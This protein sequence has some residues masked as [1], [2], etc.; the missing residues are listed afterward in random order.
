[1]KDSTLLA[2]PAF[3]IAGAISACAVYVIWGR[4]RHPVYSDPYDLE[5]QPYYSAV[6]DLIVRPE[7][8][9]NDSNNSG[10]ST[11]AYV[12][13]VQM[14][15]KVKR[16]PNCLTAFELD[17]L[18]PAQQLKDVKTIS[19]KNSESNLTAKQVPI[20]NEN[21]AIT[22]SSG[23]TVDEN[24]TTLDSTTVTTTTASTTALNS[25][26]TAN[27]TVSIV[28][29]ES[30]NT[31]T[32]EEDNDSKQ[33]TPTEKDITDVKIKPVLEPVIESKADIPQTFNIQE[34]EEEGEQQQ[35][36]QSHPDTS[37]N[38]KG[39]DV[40]C[41][42]CQTVIGKEDFE[43]WELDQ[44]PRDDKVEV[45]VLPCNHCFHDKC[46]SPWILE[47]RAD[48]PLCKRALINEVT[49]D[50]LKLELEEESM[51]PSLTPSDSRDNLPRNN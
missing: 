30:I 23:S 51:I 10:E 18:F 29:P 49:M 39:A 50:I 6:A 35:K 45:R 4:R 40:I 32:V 41:S 37:Q 25:K 24:T 11:E 26:N 8:Y 38:H 1:M 13:W 19:P 33:Q 36:N 42:I 7:D 48:C 3:F 46:I 20:V 9:N 28:Q 17:M 5:S 47:R 43:D 22:S 2:L 27:S 44:V 31:T 12:S 15:S 21:S 34:E 16:K 14:L